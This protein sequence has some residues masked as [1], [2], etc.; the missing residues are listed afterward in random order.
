MELGKTRTKKSTP[1]LFNFFAVLA[2]HDKTSDIGSVTSCRRKFKDASLQ[3]KYKKW[4]TFRKQGFDQE[5]SL[6]ISKEKKEQ[7]HYS[8]PLKKPSG[9]QGSQ[10][11]ESNEQG[12]HRQQELH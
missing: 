4:R 2:G 7:K 5:N 1:D 10:L 8:R 9:T 3:K 12:L 6:K 11:I